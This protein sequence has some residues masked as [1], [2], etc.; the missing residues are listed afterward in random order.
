[1]VALAA[2]G[3]ALGFTVLGGSSTVALPTT[4]QWAPLTWQHPILAANFIPNPLHPPHI[5]PDTMVRSGADLQTVLAPLGGNR[6]RLHVL[7][8]SG[9]GFINT[10]HWF[11]PGGWTIAKVIGSTSGTCTLSGTSGAG[12]NLF[13]TVVLN[14]EIRCQGISLKPPTCTCRGDGGHLDIVFSVTKSSY[15]AGLMAGS[16]RIEAGTPVLKIIP[17]SV[18][19]AD[20]PLCRS[21]Q[22]STKAIPCAPS[23]NG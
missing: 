4:G 9:I 19:R 16:V 1:M 22:T 5:D 20:I 18:Q 6:Y 17:S 10:F 12:G 23:G 21:G 3:V 15:T 11:P 13:P 2:A 7:N 14:P 8:S